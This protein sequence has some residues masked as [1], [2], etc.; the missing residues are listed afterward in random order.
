MRAAQD[1]AY[2]AHNVPSPHFNKILQ[3][4]LQECEAL[5]TETRGETVTLF[6]ARKRYQALMSKH[7]AF[8]RNVEDMQKGILEIQR[9]RE[10]FIRQNIWEKATHIAAWFKNKDILTM[11]EVFAI[12]MLET[13]KRFGSR[14]SSFVYEKN[15]LACIPVPEKKIGRKRV[16]ILQK[17]NGKICVRQVRVRPLPKRELWFEKVWNSFKKERE[18]LD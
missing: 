6:A 9:Q 1:I 17:T 13:A 11:Q 15:F 18:L 12:G 8:L 3:A 2:R 16:V 7:F 10:N 4:A 14:G 5:L